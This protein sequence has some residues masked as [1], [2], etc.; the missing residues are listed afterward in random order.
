MGKPT[1]WLLCYVLDN[2]GY[3]KIGGS[4]WPLR[5]EKNTLYEGGVKAVGFVWSHESVRTR[6][7]VKRG[8][9]GGTVNTDLL[10]IT[11]WYPTILGLA[12]SNETLPY[13]TD[14]FDMWP[15]LRWV[16]FYI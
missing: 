4:N 9:R 8:V 7:G 16:H 13:D 1:S 3:L 11:D 6:G 12:R 14:G 15:L 2:G 10:H 5:G